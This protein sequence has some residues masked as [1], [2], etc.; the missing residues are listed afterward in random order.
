MNTAAFNYSIN[1]DHVDIRDIRTRAHDER[2]VKVI[3]PK[4][5]FY[6]KSYEFRVSTLWNSF[7]NDI[8]SYKENEKFQRWNKKRFKDILYPPDFRN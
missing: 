5:P 2:L 7:N 1:A 6:R 8:R 3:R 4:N